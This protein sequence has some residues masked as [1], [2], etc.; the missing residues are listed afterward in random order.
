MKAG[1]W[2]KSFGP[3]LITVSVVIGPGSIITANKAGGHFGYDLI[4]LLIFAAFLMVSYVLMAARVGCRTDSSVLKLAAELYGRPVAILTGISCFFV[5][6][7]FQF[8]NNLGVAT[9]ME[10]LTGIGEIWWPVIIT[11]LTIT[12]FFAMGGLYQKLE[13]GM[14]ILVGIIVLAFIVN[15][16]HIGIDPGGF[17]RGFVPSLPENSIGIVTAMLAT[18]F[19]VVAALY[20]AHLVKEKRWKGADSGKVKKD[21]IF[22]V[23]VLCMIN[24][25]ILCGAAGAFRETPDIELKSAADLA[26]LFEA[27]LGKFSKIIFCLGLFAAAFS[28]FVVNA[29]IGGGLLAD[30]LGLDAQL[31]SKPAKIC[32]TLAM[33]IGMGVAMLALFLKAPPVP[34]IIIAQASTLL[35][36]PI[37]AVLLLMLANNRKVMGDQRNGIWLNLLG[38][39]G[40]LFLIGNACL[41]CKNL[42]EK[43]F[44]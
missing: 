18:N 15:L 26:G 38:G 7:G 35:A 30:G 20:Q 12:G 11:A 17:F 1:Q 13:K 2:S 5:A 10:G 4:W 43:F 9:A 41:T 21:A 29:L 27:L 42:Y 3:G 34:S 37:C 24:V 32:T 33:L 6:A 22:G 16:V 25:I 14:K 31:D 44:S 39:I 40:L 8:G 19:S 23:S 28:S 36:V